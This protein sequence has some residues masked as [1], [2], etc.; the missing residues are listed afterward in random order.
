MQKLFNF[1]AQ[2]ETNQLP[3]R[4]RPLYPTELRA[5]VY[6]IVSY[7]IKMC[8][9]EDWVKRHEKKADTNISAFKRLFSN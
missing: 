5:L 6:Y 9:H 7:L 8:K 2:Q 3:L 4:R 1:Q